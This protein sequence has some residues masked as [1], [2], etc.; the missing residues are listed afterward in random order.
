M[1]GTDVIAEIRKMPEFEELPV[2]VM[3]SATR[4]LAADERRDL[5]VS[6]C[7]TKPVRQAR[8]RTCL[9][10]V[11]ASH[12]LESPGESAA[13]GTCFNA[14]VLLVEDNAVN[15][16]MP[17]LDGFAATRRIRAQEES[18]DAG[19]TPIVAITAN[20]L[21][22]DR[23]NCIEA[24]MDCY[25]SKP[26][27]QE[28]LTRL[29]TDKLPA[30]ARAHAAREST[31]APVPE[32]DHA[33]LD[34]AALEPIREM[35][36][37]DGMPLLISLVELYEDDARQ[38]LDKLEESCDREDPAAAS[39]AAHRLKSSSGNLGARIVAEHS[40]T[41]EKMARKGNLTD[42]SSLVQSLKQEFTRAIAALKD[43]VALIEKGYAAPNC[44]VSVAGPGGSGSA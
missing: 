9:V 21:A 44:A 43:E 37:P 22:G 30:E 5:G 7:L 39:A 3:S 28:E 6:A 36:G 23:E 8:L 27:T 13:P 14:R 20:A 17:R 4:S 18:K 24:G 29:L 19:R 31:K 15:Q 38:L 10:S 26:F 33:T 1:S 2:V 32:S 12:E 16:Q 34:L 41:L 40:A 42:A 25:L 35:H 11:F